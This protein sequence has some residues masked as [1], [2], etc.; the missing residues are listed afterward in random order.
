MPFVGAIRARQVHSR[1]NGHAQKQV[2]ISIV[3]PS[4]CKVLLFALVKYG[5]MQPMNMCADTC[6]NMSINVW[7][8]VSISMCVSMHMAMFISRVDK[9]LLF[10]LVKCGELARAKQYYE[11][12][13]EQVAMPTLVVSHVCIDGCMV[14]ICECAATVPTRA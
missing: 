7:T 14:Y 2:F 4:V 10:A 13:R 3:I 6:I 9:V 5:E 11:Q 12:M 1:V 8:N